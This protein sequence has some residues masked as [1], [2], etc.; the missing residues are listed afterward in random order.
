MVIFSISSQQLFTELDK[1]KSLQDEPQT[2]RGS[3][4]QKIYVK[5]SNIL[6][7]KLK[8]RF[9]HHKDYILFAGLIGCIL[10]YN[11]YIGCTE[12]SLNTIPKLIAF[13]Y[14]DISD[15]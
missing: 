8:L 6:G 11:V 12:C 9:Y 5:L 3:C 10:M 4:E 14:A 7:R 13:Y 15:A 1:E 2:S